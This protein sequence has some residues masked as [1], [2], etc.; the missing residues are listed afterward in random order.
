VIYDVGCINGHAMNV[1]CIFPNL[2][3]YENPIFDYE[4]LVELVIQVTKLMEAFGVNVQ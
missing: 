4:E 2:V 3:N 1:W